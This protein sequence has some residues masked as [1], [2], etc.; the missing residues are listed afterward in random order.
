M[1]IGKSLENERNKKK[2]LFV[3][4]GDEDRMIS[5]SHAKKI[6]EVF[7]GKKQIRI[8]EGSHN[9]N[10]PSSVIRE[11]FYFIETSLGLEPNPILMSPIN[12]KLKKIKLKEINSMT[13]GKESQ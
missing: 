1:E 5:P 8:F 7:P 2:F 10:R 12:K 4:A 13:G 11:C 3:M 6:F 9:S